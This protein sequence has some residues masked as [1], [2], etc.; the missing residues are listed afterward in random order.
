LQAGLEELY[1]RNWMCRF[2]QSVEKLDKLKNPIVSGAA[3]TKTY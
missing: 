2:A 1:L 3:P